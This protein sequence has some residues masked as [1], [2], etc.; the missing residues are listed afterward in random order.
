M[1]N[2]EKLSNFNNKDTITN[3]ENELKLWESQLGKNYPIKYGNK[4]VSKKIKIPSL[5]PSN[6]K[7]VIGY[8]D[9]ADTKDIDN[10]IKV[11]KNTFLKWRSVDTEK[12]SNLFLKIAEKLKIK[13]YKF[14]S[15]MTLEAGKSW[16][17]MLL[18]QLIF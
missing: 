12:K 4:I 13:K 15:L 7:Q 2:F 9:A 11:A 6:H 8:L 17:Q 18:K 14:A 5:N 16:M 3:Y 10:A 1:F